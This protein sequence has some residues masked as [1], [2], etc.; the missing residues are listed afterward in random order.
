MKPYLLYIDIASIVND[1]DIT[2]EKNGVRQQQIIAGLKKL[3]EYKFATH[4]CDIMISDNTCEELATKFKEVI[5]TEV[6]HR[7]FTDNRYGSINK[8]AGLVQKW[9]HNADILQQYEWMIHFEGRLLLRSFEFFDRFFA[10]PT[11]YFTYGSK[12][13][14]DTSHFFTGLFSAKTDDILR[15][16]DLFPKEKLIHNRISIEYPISDY[17]RSKVTVLDSVDVIWFCARSSPVKY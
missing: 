6:L 9:I 2:M 1:N 7:C 15:F 5:P 3:F 16:C 12:T 10:S 17:L 14:G 4:Q 13:P 11:Y 8:G